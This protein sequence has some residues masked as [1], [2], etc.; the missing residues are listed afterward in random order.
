MTPDRRRLA[1]WPGGA[2]TA[3]AVPAAVVL[4]AVVLV[5]VV[6]A[7]EVA[8]GR[9]RGLFVAR[10]DLLAVLL[11]WLA[12]AVL[13]ARV[14]AGLRHAVAATLL[15]A[16]AVQGV[17]LLYGPQQSDDLYR[18]VWD[19]RVQAA[20]VDPYRYPPQDPALAGLRTP[21]L[22]AAGE[23]CTTLRE[24]RPAAAR[25]DPFAGFK[26]DPCTSINRPEVRTIYPPAAQLAF[27]AAA[28]VTPGSWPVELQVQVPAALASLLLTLLLVLALRRTG[29]PP[30]SALAYA[31]GPLAGLEAAMDGHVDVLAALLGLGALLL[32]SRSA[33]A[34]RATAVGVLLT[35]A[36]LT[37]LYPAALGAVL[38]GTWRAQPRRLLL[39][40]GAGLLAAAL[41]YAP[42]VAAVGLDVIGYLPGYLRENG[43]DSGTRYLLLGLVVPD[44]LT[45][46]VAA[47]GLLVVVALTVARRPADGPVQAC[48]AGAACFGAALLVL[49]PGDAWYCTLLVAL[50]LV[51]GVWRWLP[52]VAANYVAYAVAL[53]HG[54]PRWGTLAY[55]ASAGVVVAAVLRERR[56]AG[57]GAAAR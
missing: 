25:T 40:A 45:P 30:A 10:Y 7:C 37:K 32:L 55:A 1:S 47:L 29:Q 34:R 19:A 43:Y 21:D 14:V 57:L 17:G 39:A 36:V 46:A 11:L 2:A 53:L 3:G 35:L 22:W 38:L 8:T 56:D 33:S 13:L 52:L 42:H 41:L 50:A 20:G 15:V 28:L 54:D 26:G 48:R 9:S 4:V 18:Y 27:R 5:G 23:A 6:L 51:G 49:T 12:A 24:A 44:R 16:L 31:A